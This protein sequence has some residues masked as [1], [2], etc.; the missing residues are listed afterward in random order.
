M[1][2]LPREV[3]CQQVSDLYRVRWEIEADNKLDKSCSQMDFVDC[4]NVHALHALIHASLVSS[5]MACL[6]AH[7]H[8]LKETRPK[9]GESERKVAPIHPQVLARMIGSMSM[10]IAGAMD[11]RGEE[12]KLKWEFITKTLEHMGKDPNWRRSPSI[13][14]QLR[15]W[16]IHPGKSK[17]QKM[18]VSCGENA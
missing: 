5:M 13:L 4:K 7:H 1:T 6:I 9:R 3:A 16:K 2:S 11:L 10:T 17:P 18:A 14:D 15:G 8:R 12:A